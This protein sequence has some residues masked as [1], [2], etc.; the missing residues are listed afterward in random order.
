MVNA[1]LELDVTKCLK[2]GLRIS[3]LPLS[4]HIMPMGAYNYV[5]SMSNNTLH[6]T[7]LATVL[8]LY[9]I[10]S[11]KMEGKIQKRL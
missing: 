6:W 8:I 9:F 4:F 5:F 7:E 10:R 3:P 2:L 11:S 1:S